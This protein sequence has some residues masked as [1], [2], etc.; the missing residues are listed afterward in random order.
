SRAGRGA[1][2]VP[3]ED[4]EPAEGFNGAIQGGGEVARVR[5]VAAHG[6]RADAVGLAFE[7]LPAPSEHRDVGPFGCERLG[8][9]EPETGRRA[10][11]DRRAPLEPE[12]HYGTACG[13]VVRT[14]G[15]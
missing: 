13:A 5:H 14:Q 1:A 10:A 4:V 2:A 15:L 3:D 11:D 6:K 8:R 12:V 7:Q 9:R